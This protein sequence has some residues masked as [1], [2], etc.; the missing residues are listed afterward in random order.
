MIF[1]QTPHLHRHFLRIIFW[2]CCFY[3]SIFLAHAQPSQ[4][5]P[6]LKERI[7]TG[8]DA[9]YSMRYADAAR[10][11][12]EIIAKYPNEPTG[13][14]FRSQIHLWKFLFDYSEPDYR[15]F[16]QQ[17]DKAI[18][19]AETTLK[20]RPDNTFAQTIVGAVYGFRAM[21]NFRAENFMKATLDGRSC[22]NYLSA[23]VKTNP[24]EYDAFLGMGMFHF[25]VAAMPSVVRSVANFAGLKGDLEGGLAEIR[26]AAE[27]SIWARNDA[28]MFLAMI[29]VYYKRDFTQGV[30]YLNDL[31]ERYPSNV[32]ILYSRANVEL[33]VRKPQTA[34]PLYQKVSQYADTNFRAFSAFAR[35][36][37]GECYWRMNDFESAKREFQRFFK[38]RYERSF[39]GNAL[40]RLA[41]CYEMTGN[42]AEA[43][44]GYAKCTALTPFEPDDRFAIRRAKD[45]TKKA[46]EGS[47]I[48][49]IKGVNAVESSRFQEAEQLLRP[50]TE[51]T[52]ISRE[53][54]SEAAYNLAEALREQQRMAEAIPLYLKAVEFEPQEERW[55]MP[56]SYYRIAEIH[57]N[58]GK[59]DLS[60]SYIEKAKV[61]SGYDFQEWLTFLMERDATMLKG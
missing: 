58:A 48:Q 51:N 50:L 24:K 7:N 14:F 57:F 52:S 43:L 23:V 22:Y 34:L 29:N 20:Q 2:C 46:L 38:G 53:I 31:L 19:V 55:V 8:L 3:S 27:Q 5:S 36:R 18:S 54:R 28:A 56:W 12:E 10:A 13:Y 45:Y 44:K 42:R 49:L 26:M 30:K 15:L 25:G 1:L 33:F 40:L 32:P 6:Y 41:L 9:M 21:A 4:A 37:M 59:R 35:Y 39:R 16:L 11:F 47:Q 61:F 17:C 60:R